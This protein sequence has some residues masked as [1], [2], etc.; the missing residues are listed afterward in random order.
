MRGYARV[1]SVSLLMMG[2]L[3]VPNLSLATDR[4]GNGR[5]SLLSS[6]LRSKIQHL[7]DKMANHR[8]H[9]H[10][11]RGNA[12]SVAALR[13]EVT[14]LQNALAEMTSNEAALLLVINQRLDALEKP[15]SGGGSTNPALTELA[16]YVKVDPGTINGLKGPHVIFHHA[17]VHV[18][19]GS[20]VIPEYDI[21]ANGSVQARPNALNGLGNLIV[22]YNDTPAPQGYVNSASHNLVVGSSHTFTSLG[23]VVFG[24]NNLSS[25]PYSTV[26][27]GRQNRSLGPA[28]SLLGGFNLEVRTDEETYP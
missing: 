24:H 25:G 27:G 7:R 21:L 28:S 26:L 4:D 19:S 13:E 6:E 18:E 8:E 5:H 14:Y 2:L 10:N 20:G 22:G 3:A 17:N 16:K 15:Q 23:G 12:D 1:V 11:Q 9:H